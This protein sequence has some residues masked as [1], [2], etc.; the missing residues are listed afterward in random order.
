MEE[1]K[2]N[3][4][5]ANLDQ[6]KLRR[7]LNIKQQYDKG[8]L[9]LEEARVRMK[10]E[11]GTISAAEF[12]AAEQLL[13]DEDPDECRNEDV[14]GMLEAFDGLMNIEETVLP[15]GHTIDAYLRENSRMKELL[16]QGDVF[17]Q[18]PFMLNSWLELMEQ[19]LPYKVHFTRKQ[20]QLY[21]ALEREG[22]D[23]PTNTMWVYD[24]Y[25]RDEM[26]KAW[27]ILQSEPVD[28]I[29]FLDTYGEMAADLRDLMEKE[30]IILYPTSLKLISA[31]KMEQLKS[32][33]QEIGYFGIELQTSRESEQQVAGEHNPLQRKL[34]KATD[35]LAD[36]NDFMQDLTSLLAKYGHETKND[37]QDQVLD[38]AHGK[39]TL[40]QI[41]LLYQ[42]MPVDISFVDENE[43]V[44]FYTDTK[45]RVFPRSKGVID[46]EVRNCHPPKS[47]HL[48]EEI[49][50]KFRSG[51]Q[52]KAEFWI[53][54]PDLFIYIVYI[55]VRDDKGN[56]R[57][58]MEMM[59]DC[60]HIRQLEGEQRL[61]SWGTDSVSGN[62]A[63]HGTE[64]ETYT[65]GSNGGVIPNDNS[66]TLTLSGDTKLKW[67][68]QQF[69]RL[70]DDLIAYNSKFSILNSPMAKV[71][72]PIA[73]IKMMS[74]QSGIPR[75][76]LIDKI[77]ELILQN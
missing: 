68:L 41:N 3:H 13:K 46:R 1:P 53:N 45:H 56:F 59:Q 20:N 72:L 75:Q 37:K 61:L 16:Q 42:H 24:D 11:V 23:R 10:N 25:I 70:K 34:E 77:N 30:E 50:E 26:N 64:N 9:P 58:V 57:G 40:E 32:G 63:H 67:L 48:V 14:R 36:Q 18:K 5:F 31:E 60:T 22:F 47:I 19:I 73:T 17:A 39:L 2:I 69:P 12:A 33:D 52:S 51:E 35:Q 8:D 43:L 29:S 65:S 62:G 49:I 54:K 4:V 21:S 44:K 7:M 55:A 38:V 6:E 28:T 27:E 76:E 15:Y 71:I 66:E 74:E